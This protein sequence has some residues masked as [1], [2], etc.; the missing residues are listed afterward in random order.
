MP[1]HHVETT[2]THLALPTAP[3]APGSALWLETRPDLRRSAVI[4]GDILAALGKRRD[5]AG[6]G[7]NENQDI[8]LSIAWMHAYDIAALVLTEAQRLSPLVMR[9]I[10]SVAKAAQVP[11]WLLHRAP[12]SDAFIHTLDRRQGHPGHLDEVPPPRTWKPAAGVR[13]TLKAT[14]PS[15]GFHEFLTAC[16]ATLSPAANARVALRHASTANRC[17]QVLQRDGAEPDVLAH[18][19]EEILRTAPQDDLLVTDIRALQLAAWHN[20]VYLKSD[21]HLLL[22]SSERQL[23][24]P[25]TVDQTLIGYRQPHRAVAVTLAMHQVGVHAIHALQIQNATADGAAISPAGGRTIEMPQH[26]ARAVRALLHLRAGRAAGPTSPLLDVSERAVSQALNDANLDLNIRVHGRRA[27][28]HAHPQRWLRR[29]G[30]TPH[31][32]T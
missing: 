16:K 6:I 30:L 23:N 21:L 20:D 17:H 9:Q 32:L 19:A 13:P 31:E 5:V 18:L 14:L 25:V 28:R 3:A 11:L 10:I 24:D 29:L 1:T 7:R 8:A 26:A 27:E 2:G 4:A 12:R 15:V 22:A